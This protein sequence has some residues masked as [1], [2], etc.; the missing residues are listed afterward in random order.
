MTDDT[1]PPPPE[2]PS[3]YVS[4][5]D[6]ERLIAHINMPKTVVQNTE[7]V[8]LETIQRI[9][10]VEDQLSTHTTVWQD[11]IVSRKF[12]LDRIEEDLSDYSDKI[13]ALTNLVQSQIDL[14]T[15]ND[16]RMRM[17]VRDLYGFGNGDETRV[18]GLIGRMQRNEAITNDLAAKIRFRE[19]VLG[20]VV[21]PLVKVMQST[22]FKAIVIALLSGG[23]IAAI[24]EILKG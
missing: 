13:E 2:H 1:T 15:E 18:L 14:Q 9:E 11:S 16:E 21:P 3:K 4:I 19:G 17:I 6:I 22:V 12:Q 20:M 7:F 24:V 23:G 8:L 10:R 5:E